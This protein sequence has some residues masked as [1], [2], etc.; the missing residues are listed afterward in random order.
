MEREGRCGDG[1][2]MGW[3]QV[4]GL[5]VCV[6]R[7]GSRRQRG[8]AALGHVVVSALVH[9]WCSKRRTTGGGSAGRQAGE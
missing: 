5:A 8:W 4:T 1:A 7:G 2:S 3:G 6:R 9:V